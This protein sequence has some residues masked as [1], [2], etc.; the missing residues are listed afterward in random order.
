MKNL[1]KPLLFFT[2]LFSLT[3]FSQEFYMLGNEPAIITKTELNDKISSFNKR[4]KTLKRK[5]HDLIINYKII[6]T[7]KRND[8]LIYKAVHTYN[9]VSNKSEKIYLL[10]NKKLPE[11]NLKDINAKKVTLKSLN[12]KVTF[13]NLWFTKCFP[14]VKEIPLLNILQKKYNTKVNFLAITY[15]SKKE[16]NNFLKKKK[17]NFKHII[18][19]KKYINESLGIGTY[20][21]IIIVDSNNIIK[22]IGDGIPPEY[23]YIKKSM[24]KFKEK[25]LL[26]LEK[27]IDRLL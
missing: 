22:Y 21:K 15:N 14:C 18:N 1:K 8:S 12:N 17:F 9:Y 26:Y 13:I 4:A 11:L 25:D 3:C 6:D 23:D 20:P 16:V 2:Y 7:I 5:S 24:K 27:V 19:A 10:E